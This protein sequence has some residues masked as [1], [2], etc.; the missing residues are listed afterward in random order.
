MRMNITIVNQHRQDKMGGSEL[1]CDFIAEGLTKK[2][3]NVRYVAVGGRSV[4]YG[5]LYSV[6]PCENESDDIVRK[7]MDSNPDVVYWRYNKNFLL[8]TVYSLYKQNIPVIFAAS[9]IDDVC[10]FTTKKGGRIVKRMKR[11]FKSIKHHY[12]FKYVTAVTVNNEDY[13][14]RI[15]KKP[16]FYIPNGM[17]TNYEQFKWPRPYCCWIASLKVVKRPELFIKLAK[18]FENSGVDFLMI[19]QI[20]EKKYEWI[21]HKKHNL[22]KNFY[23]LGE[24]SFEEVNGILK[25]SLFHI[26]TC[27]NEGFPNVFIQ[28][29]KQG[30]ASVSYGF[31][32]SGCIEEFNLGYYSNENWE[33]FI[34]QVEKLIDNDDLRSLFSSNAKSFSKEKFT[35]EK[36]VDQIEDVLLKTATN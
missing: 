12:A 29:W 30:K 13:L 16:Q 25:N 2:N 36:M 19:G 5:T 23:Y 26:H 31:D 8:E 6:I 9:H 1:Q 15:K 11:L 34:N 7:V 3:H 21:N 10:L 22:A 20:Q 33:K 32:P 28:A 4:D 17:I 35:I 18:E 24:K 14:N 27:L